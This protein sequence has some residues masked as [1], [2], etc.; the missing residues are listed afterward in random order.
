M[1]RH[2]KPAFASVMYHRV[3]KFGWG[4]EVEEK[5]AFTFGREKTIG[6]WLRVRPRSFFD[7]E[8]KE[9]VLTPEWYDQYTHEEGTPMLLD[10]ATPRNVSRAIREINGFQW[11]GDFKP[12]A[13]RA[14]KQPLEKRLEE[15]MAE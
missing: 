7:W 11:E 13:R 3:C 14:L 5:M 10:Q 8:I 9:G 12:M 6:R 4:E 15:E 1:I 2:D